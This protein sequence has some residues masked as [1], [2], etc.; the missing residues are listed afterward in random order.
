VRNYLPATRFEMNKTTLTIIANVIIGL[1]NLVITFLY[2]LP[3]VTQIFKS[4]GGGFGFGLLLIPFLVLFLIM[5]I[6]C[7]AIL[8]RKGNT[9]Y[10]SFFNLVTMAVF[11][12]VLIWASEI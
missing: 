8:I 7:V 10:F 2:F 4:S 12:F 3:F 9:T 1:T 5:T 6:T 11:I